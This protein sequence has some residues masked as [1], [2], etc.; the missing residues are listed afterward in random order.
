MKPRIMCL[1]GGAILALGPLVAL[2]QN[3]T[4]DLE[5]GKALYA[6]GDFRGS[7]QTLTKVIEKAPD[8][9]DARRE[10]GRALNRLQDYQAAL[11][12]LEVAVRKNPNDAVAFNLRG[13]AKSR[14][15]DKNGAMADYTQAIGLDP[16]YAGP[17]GNRAG[18]RREAGD[19]A[20]A[21]Q[22]YDRALAIA[23]QDE[24]CLWGRA[25]TRAMTGDLAGALTDY[26]QAIAVNPKNAGMHNNR[27]N[28]LMKMQNYQEAL[29]SFDRALEI[30]PKHV[31][32]LTNRGLTRTKLGDWAGALVDLKSALTI[33]PK[34]ASALAGLADLQKFARD[35]TAAAPGMKKVVPVAPGPDPTPFIK[36]GEELAAR[37]K[38]AEAVAA[39][40]KAIDARPS[41]GSLYAVRGWAQ[42][43]KGDNQEAWRDLSMTINLVPGEARA[44][45]LR[46]LVCQH[47]DRFK[48]AVQDFSE[49]ARLDPKSARASGELAMVLNHLRDHAGAVAAASEAIKR[50]PEIHGYYQVRAL[51]YERLGLLPEALADLGQATAKTNDSKARESLATIRQRVVAAQ[52]GF[53]TSSESKMIV[54]REPEPEPPASRGG[55]A[56]LVTEGKIAMLEA[57]PASASSAPPRAP[58]QAAVAAPARPTGARETSIKPPTV[59]KSAPPP[60]QLIWKVA[61][62]GFPSGWMVSKGEYLRDGSNLIA[63][64]GEWALA[65]NP[66]FTQTLY[67]RR[68][69]DP[70]ERYQIRSI[71]EVG[72]A[73][74]RDYSSQEK[75]DA[76]FRDSRGRMTPGYRGTTDARFQGLRAFRYEVSPM[77][78]VKEWGYIV[79]LDPARKLWTTVLCHVRATYS[80]PRDEGPSKEEQINRRN[81]L[82]QNVER[83]LAKC[84]R[85]EQG[86]PADEPLALELQTDPAGKTELRAD[87]RDGLVL[88]LRV[89]PK[90][91]A[92]AA[93]A[94]TAT[95]TIT[96]AATGESAQWV[97]LGEAQ[98]RDG[99]KAIY[100]QAS[101]PDPARG[102]ASPPTALQVRA[103]T[104]AGGRELV[105]LITLGVAADC[106]IDARPDRA[107]FLAKS[108]Q[109]ATIEVLVSDPAKEPWEFRA[110][111]AR[112][113]RPVARFQIKRTGPT[114][115]VLE[116]T[117]AGLEPRPDTPSEIVTLR[118]FAAKQGAA[119]LER[120]V[121]V[122]VGQEGLFVVPIGKASDGFFHVAADGRKVAKEI[123]FRVTVWDP[124]ARRLVA[125]G[126]LAQQLTFA[127]DPEQPKTSIHAL[128]VAGLSTTGQ[129]AKGGVRGS[130]DP[131]GIY[132]FA[133]GREV[134]ADT[135]F[136]PVR[137]RVT[138]RGPTG[139]EYAAMLPLA[140]D[141]VTIGPE[142]ADWK[143]EYERCQEV[144]NR[145]VPAKYWPKLNE[146]LEKRKMALGP[147]G[148]YALRHQLWGIAVNLTLHEG[149]EG[150]AKLEPWE[151]RMTAILEWT[152]WGSKV[153]FDALASVAVGPV[154]GAALSQAHEMMKSAL[155][156]LDQGELPDNFGDW[157]WNQTIGV[158][159]LSLTSLSDPQALIQRFEAN[160]AEAFCICVAYQFTYNVVFQKQTVA[161]AAKN[162]AAYA[163]NQALAGWLTG[164]IMQH[165]KFLATMKVDVPPNET[166]L[167]SGELGQMMAGRKGTMLNSTEAGQWAQ[168]SLAM[169]GLPWDQAK[170]IWA[171]ISR[172]YA[173]QARGKVAV[174]LEGGVQPGKIFSETELG[175]L[176]KNPAVT[177]INVFVREGG[178]WVEK[179]LFKPK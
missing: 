27:G 60:A 32:A 84:I 76:G 77:S 42:H 166:V 177:E 141:P 173:A 93:M 74:E 131:S 105:R 150:W 4:G 2:A 15:G 52:R 155:V 129:I 53:A 118:V 86:P 116:L 125:D 34:K 18:L 44:Y 147:Q 148:L 24:R 51:A 46:G 35:A 71:V 138:A 79:E 21:M 120:H 69:E 33:D 8:D 9:P 70:S 126:A 13:N 56:P 172:R 45:L 179:N 58:A 95:E 132:R 149:D 90:D 48:E 169:Q 145:F 30:D 36:R 16:K 151:S 99:W 80:G 104:M 68:S 101:N 160:K 10:R 176:L 154:Y 156:A 113:D 50:E 61:W 175:A 82:E 29:A 140:L 97:D 136:V 124:Q 19:H 83:V 163:L 37:G 75:I 108:G 7:V 47:M 158:L 153:A 28:A 157:F 165:P 81:E 22:D 63:S 174:Y 134:P 11:A 65:D 111:Y 17:L 170:P 55:G 115:A 110:E 38:Y 20:G 92:A 142:S 117:E 26:N 159:H 91:P 135:K 137:M 78:T 164:K 102:T 107:E 94:A 161:D 64:A 167:W 39:Y 103:T 5:R 41:D 54:S 62:G 114:R 73:R 106:A 12:D 171:E 96:F 143:I 123:D 121:K 122:S 88:K 72:P 1:V 119:P 6:A 152:E 144:I 162:A 87:G 67:F 168:D 25:D 49:A 89:K 40:S 127:P 128:E 146:I 100:V 85:I 112:G 23:P 57:A 178:K 59:A 66:A 109:S 3:R 133:A 98:L 31:N 43:L 139:R 130:N 14:L